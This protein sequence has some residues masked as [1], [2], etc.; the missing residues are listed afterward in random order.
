VPSVLIAAVTAAGV[1]VFGFAGS[2]F[3]DWQPLTAQGAVLLLLAQG[4]LL[5][6]YLAVVAAMRRGEVSFVA[7]F[8]YSSLLAS[9]L[10]GLMLFGTWPQPLTLLGAAVVAGSGVALIWGSRRV[11]G[12]GT[13][14]AA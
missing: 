1:T 8:R 10:M 3:V 6:G 9:L 7:P 4:A 5:G 11:A 14:P 13:P 12:E 2:L